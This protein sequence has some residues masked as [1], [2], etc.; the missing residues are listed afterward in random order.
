[1]GWWE[2]EFRRADFAKKGREGE[3]ELV[4]VLEECTEA[5]NRNRV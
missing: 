3:K 2:D 5:T 1:M 4:L